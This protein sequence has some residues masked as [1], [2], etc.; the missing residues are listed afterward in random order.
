MLQDTRNKVI[1]AVSLAASGDT[2]AAE[3]DPIIDVQGT[4]GVAIQVEVGGGNGSGAVTVSLQ[5]SEDGTTWNDCTYE[6]VVAD[7]DGDTSISLNDT[8]DTRKAIGYSG[9]MRYVRGKVAGTGTAITVNCINLVQPQ[10][11][12]TPIDIPA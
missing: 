1:A 12:K 8:D 6:A 5:E 3:T 2:I 9:L 10:M 11:T 7:N 4:I